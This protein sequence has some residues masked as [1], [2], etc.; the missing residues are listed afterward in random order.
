MDGVA[1][2][3]ISKKRAE[4]GCPPPPLSCLSQFFQG[5]DE[6]LREAAPQLEVGG[7]RARALGGRGAQ[8]ASRGSGSSTPRAARSLVYSLDWQA[9]LLRYARDAA[10]YTV[11]KQW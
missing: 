1:A 9:Y 5:F 3:H 4:S 11:R 10:Q 2:I 7:A 6:A 8:G